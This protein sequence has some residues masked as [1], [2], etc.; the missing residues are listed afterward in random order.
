LSRPRPTERSTRGT[1]PCVRAYARLVTR[2]MSER[3]FHPSHPGCDAMRVDGPP[4]F[5]LRVGMRHE[6]Y[7][8]TRPVGGYPSD[9]GHSTTLCTHTH[10]HRALQTNKNKKHKTQNEV[11]FSREKRD[12]TIPP[13]D[14]ERT[15][16]KKI[17]SMCGPVCTL[18]HRRVKTQNTS[19]FAI[20]TVGHVEFCRR[21][22]H[23]ACD[24]SIDRSRIE[25]I[26]F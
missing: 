6:K 16:K 18:S 17:S 23:R 20:R 8:S 12:C 4:F 11:A 3:F 1:A 25:M 15:G 9:D 26:S 21:R 2:R 14:G 24:R 7:L 22:A 5:R 19:I 10:T 13:A